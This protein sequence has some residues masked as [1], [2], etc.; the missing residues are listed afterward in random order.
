MFF[1]STGDCGCSQTGN[2]TPVFA[3]T[4]AKLC[5]DRYHTLVTSAIGQMMVVAKG[6]NCQ[7]FLRNAV[8]PRGFV[9]YE[10][11]EVKILGAPILTLPVLNPAVSG[12]HP[13]PPSGFKFLLAGT[14]EPAEW[15]HV[16]A[17][18]AGT[19]VLQSI[20]G[21][22]VLVD[23]GSI[24]GINQ[25]GLSSA[26]TPKGGMM[27]IV[28]TAPGSNMFALRRL[29]VQHERVVVGDIDELGVAG[30]KPL[31]PSAPLKHD[32]GQF[33]ETRFRTLVGL[34]SEGAPIAGGLEQAVVTGA[35]SITDG[36]RMV[37]SP[38]QKRLFR[39]PAPTYAFTQV[40]TA[41]ASTLPAIDFTA[42]PA[43]HG[44][45]QSLNYSYPTV[46]IDFNITF[47]AAEN[48]VLGLYRDGILL[49]QFPNTATLDGFGFFFVDT[50]NPLGAHVYDVR[51]KKTSGTTGAVI[52]RSS[53]LITTMA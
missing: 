36:V 22:F 14:G 52:S 20:N 2:D 16:A 32:I 41:S 6:S 27:M 40:T 26:T 18:T 10:G 19:W 17:P 24:P 3:P 31:S 38:A 12:S 5:D 7:S 35:D 30:Y 43:G 33:K 34:T 9:F 23:A 29:Q 44:A 13:V 53:M 45:G 28:E 8:V 1:F 47:T 46:R 49:Q 25:V 50:S 51:W 48:F 11:E 42:M 39:A 4:G 21:T 15:R 37:Y